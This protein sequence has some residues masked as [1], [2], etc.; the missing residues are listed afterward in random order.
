[1][2]LIILHP[3][4]SSLATKKPPHRLLHPSPHHHLYSNPKPKNLIIRS[5]DSSSSSNSSLP[6]KPTSSTVAPPPKKQSSSSA[7][8]T[9][10]GSS[11]AESPTAVTKKKQKDKKERASIIRRTPVEK[12]SFATQTNEIQ[13]KEQS[14]NESAFLLA[15]LA[16]GAIIL[17]E[18]IILAASGFLPEEWDNFFVKYLYPSFTPTVFLF[19]AGTV[20]Y[21]ALKYLQTEKFKSDN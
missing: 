6:P 18:G 3:S 21:G 10:F 13:A 1:M 11:N 17:V 8:G 15:W 5:Q 4:V 12:P 14:Q 2:A 9:G 7:A 19:V 16:L 20:A